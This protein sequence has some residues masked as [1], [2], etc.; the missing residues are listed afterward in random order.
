MRKYQELIEKIRQDT[1]IPGDHDKELIYSSFIRD[2]LD[3]LDRNLEQY[4]KK[5]PLIKNM[6][7]SI[8][9]KYTPYIHCFSERMNQ[10][11]HMDLKLT[12]TIDLLWVELI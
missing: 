9:E 4:V 10:E 5:Y 8:N 3:F 1:L 6:L 11:K 12:T 2:V 7:V